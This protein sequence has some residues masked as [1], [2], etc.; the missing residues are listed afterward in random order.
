MLTFF[1][2]N[3]LIAY[4]HTLKKEGKRIGFFPTMG[5]LH[6][7]HLSLLEASK[8]TC[9]ISVCSIFVNPTQFTNPDD[10]AKYPRTVKSDSFLLESAGCDILFLP[11]QE[12]IYALEKPMSVTI[13]TLIKGFE[14]ASRP[15]HFEGVV[16][17]VRILFDCVQPDEAF[18][19]LKD[20]QQCLVIQALVNQLNLDITL[21]FI[22]TKREADGLAMSSRNQRLSSEQREE[23][24]VIYQ[25]L[26]RAKEQLGE[27]AI[28]ELEQHC[29]EQIEGETHLQVDYFKLADANTL[30]PIETLE[31]ETPVVALTAV[32]A[33]DV[34]L[35]DNLLLK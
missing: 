22:P 28:P 4:I 24:P 27:I 23:A 30:E 33:G 11:D 32:Y 25:T 29:I 3:D 7:G 34:R 15:G 14:G 5:A 2:P 19:G 31:K 10:L 16:R 35:I 26:L 20:Y 9:D 17:I 1:H 13:D 12:E 8:S 6:A 18:F 21:H